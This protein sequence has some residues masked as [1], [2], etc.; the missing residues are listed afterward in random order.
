M[1][2]FFEAMRAFA[3]KLYSAPAV[4]PTVGRIPHEQ[5]IPLEGVGKEIIA[6]QSYFTVVVNELFIAIGRQ[7]WA[8]YDPMVLVTIEYM[9]G[10]TSLAVPV[11]IGP[12]TIK[13]PTEQHI[14]HGI[15]INDIRVAG[16]H[17]YRG[18]PV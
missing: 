11:V 10:G 16:P 17:P 6:D 3:A 1:S 12:G 5:C 18:G 2:D 14:P 8:T 4:R 7:L 15:V 13:R 9:Y